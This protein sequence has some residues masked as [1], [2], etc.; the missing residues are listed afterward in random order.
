[1]SAVRRN[2]AIRSALIRLTTV[3]MTTDLRCSIVA[4]LDFRLLRDLEGVIH[5][6]AQVSDRRLKL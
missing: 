5:L 2:Q 6:D 1:M 3:A 4:R